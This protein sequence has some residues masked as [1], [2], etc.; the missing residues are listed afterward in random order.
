VAQKGDAISMGTGFSINDYGY[1]LTNYHVVENSTDISILD[2]KSRVYGATLVGYYK[3]KDIALLHADFL[4]D[5]KP[6]TLGDSSKVKLGESVVAIGC[7][8]GENYTLSVSQGIVSAKDRVM[9][10]TNGMNM[11]QTDTALN[12]G[13]SGGPLIDSHGNVIGIVTSKLLYDT[14]SSGEKIPLDGVSFA[15]P[16]NEA[17][18]IIGDWME[19]DLQKPMLGITAVSVQKGRTYFY[20]GNEGVIFG[21]QKMNNVEYKVNANGSTEVLTKAELED[22]NNKIFTAGASGLYVAKI[23][24]GLG[25]DGVLEP[26]DIITKIGNTEI[27]T[28]NDTH[29]IFDQYKA[30]D[31]MDVEI[32][33]NGSAKSVKILLKTKEDMLRAQKN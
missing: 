22:P 12:P 1:I 3:A 31:I 29:K 28:I 4:K 6:M 5:I 33:R 8:R 30:G 32:F 18:A 21:Y 20:D 27:V 9:S 14:D 10:S 24:K 16:I 13:N 2:S 25:A 15:I 19:K 17:K 7:P 26:G 23:T 11:I